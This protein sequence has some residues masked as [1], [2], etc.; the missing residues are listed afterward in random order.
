MLATKI[1][2]N[3]TPPAAHPRLMMLVQ[4]PTTDCKRQEPGCQVLGNVLTSRSRA[5]RLCEPAERARW[6]VRLACATFVPAGTTSTLAPGTTN[7]RQPARRRRP[8]TLPAHRHTAAPS[9]SSEWRAVASARARQPR[10]RSPRARGASLGFGA[11][12]APAAE[13]TKA[14][15]DAVCDTLWLGIRNGV[16]RASTRTSRS[17]KSVERALTARGKG[18]NADSRRGL[19]CRWPLRRVLSPSMGCAHGALSRRSK[20]LANRAWLRSPRESLL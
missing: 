15:Y 19:E 12:R 11:P 17:S 18:L 14:R 10:W 7:R 3:C 2:S 5:M 9:A 1:R 20:S 6:F 8:G 16:G 13:P 4:P